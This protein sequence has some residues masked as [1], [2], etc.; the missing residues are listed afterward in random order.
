MAWSRPL[1]G[2]TEQVELEQNKRLRATAMQALAGVIERSPVKTGRFR[3][4]NQVSVG[5]EESGTV[6]NNDKS[7]AATLASGAATIGAVRSPW[8]VIY[9]QNNLPYAAALEDGR[10]R[11]QAP[12]GIY[13]LTFNDLRETI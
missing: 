7:G 9:V 2:F 10:S 8:Q 4:N 13:A 12:L 11:I 6:D 3:G 5:S 1:S